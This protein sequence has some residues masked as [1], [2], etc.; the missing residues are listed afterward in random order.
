MPALAV[1]RRT[2]ATCP[3]LITTHPDHRRCRHRM[4]IA[5]EPGRSRRSLHGWAGG[6]AGGRAAT[7]PDGAHPRAGKGPTRAAAGSM[8]SLA[9]EP[10]AQGPPPARD[11]TG[12]AASR[13][14]ATPAPAAPAAEGPLPACLLCVQLV[15]ILSRLSPRL[16][17]TRVSAL[18]SPFTCARAMHCHPLFHVITAVHRRCS[19]LRK[20]AHRLGYLLRS[21]SPPRHM[22]HLAFAAGCNSTAPHLLC[23]TT[24]G[25]ITSSRT[26]AQS[27]GPHR[28]LGREGPPICGE[29]V[30]RWEHML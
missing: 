24:L 18:C 17:G 19:R 11:A 14:A 16:A 6:A 10:H 8:R 5:Q 26:D 27:G 20:A 9:S 7:R 23:H 12:R 30:G 22:A 25:Y 3:P 13:A 29:G 4:S 21:R 15:R 28:V 2:P 1:I